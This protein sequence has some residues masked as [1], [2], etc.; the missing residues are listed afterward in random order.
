VKETEKNALKQRTVMETQSL[1]HF[2][3]K[4]LSRK[5][6]DKNTKIQEHS[7]ALSTL[8]NTVDGQELELCS[9]FMICRSYN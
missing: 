8:G 2:L 9:D 6:R 7:S 5:E 4:G 3:E 1:E